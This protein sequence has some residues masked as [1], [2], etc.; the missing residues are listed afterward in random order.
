[1]QLVRREGVTFDPEVE[2]IDW[3]IST[4][5]SRD[6]LHDR[7][8]GEQHRVRVPGGGGGAE[9][10]RGRGPGAGLRGT[11]RTGRGGQARAVS[12]EF[13]DDPGVADAGP[14][15]YRH[16]VDVPAAELIDAGEIQQRRWR[17][18]VEVQTHH[19]V[20]ATENRH[21]VGPGRLLGERV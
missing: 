3:N 18:L 10:A 15:P 8:G 2:L 19:Q 9:G 17:R 14:D 7:A 20:R 13:G 12:A 11:G 4:A 6:G 1:D 21:G 5:A 16:P